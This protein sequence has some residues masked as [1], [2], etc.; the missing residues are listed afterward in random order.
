[1]GA[2]SMLFSI[3]VAMRHERSAEGLAGDEETG[4]KV[5]L[6]SFYWC[7]IN[8]ESLNIFRRFWV[9]VAVR[10]VAGL[11]QEKNGE[12]WVVG[13]TFCIVRETVGNYIQRFYA[14]F[15]ASSETMWWVLWVANG[16]KNG[17]CGMGDDLH[18]KGLY[19]RIHFAAIFGEQKLFFFE[20]VRSW[21]FVASFFCKSNQ[22]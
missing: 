20:F 13:N 21:N 18:K 16:E 12:C 14:K 3:P 7:Y 19:K 22:Y 10:T 4:N 9:H 6:T 11:W 1:M 8:R 2:V 15:P 17:H 5:F